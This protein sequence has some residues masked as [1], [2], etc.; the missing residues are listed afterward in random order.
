[1]F[2][3]EGFSPAFD[4]FDPRFSGQEL[5]QREV[6]VKAF[7]EYERNK[8]FVINKYRCGTLDGVINKHKCND[9]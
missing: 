2:E 3:N 4:F 6:K 8:T 1:M 5:T 7:N 9:K